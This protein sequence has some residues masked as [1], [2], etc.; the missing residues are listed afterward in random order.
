MKIKTVIQQQQNMV[1]LVTYA[2]YQGLGVG[3]GS[4]ESVDFWG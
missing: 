3:V 4:R 1:L 2:Q